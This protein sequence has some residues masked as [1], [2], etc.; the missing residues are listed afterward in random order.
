MRNHR[1]TGQMDC[2]SYKR[3][4]LDDRNMVNRQEYLDKM[5]QATSLMQEGK[6]TAAGEIYKSLYKMLCL[7]TYSQRLALTNT[8][9]EFYSDSTEEKIINY[10]NNLEITI[11]DTPSVRFTE[12][13][14]KAF[15]NQ[16]EK[17]KD[18][19]FDS[20]NIRLAYKGPIE[21]E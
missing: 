4:M 20:V 12:D 2:L 13:E 16:W 14:L 6:I 19:F 17:E 10:L 7:D 5:N 11:Q 9:K 21:E 15:N 1:K 8:V 18:H 3:V